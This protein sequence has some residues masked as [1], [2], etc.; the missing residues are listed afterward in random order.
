MK[1]NGGYATLQQLNHLVDFSTWGTKTPFASVRRI[2]QTNKE[3]F[4]I[5]PG[6]WALKEDEQM[7]LRKLNIVQSKTDSMDMFT[8]SYYQGILAEIGNMRNYDT[9]VPPQDKNKLFLEKKLS[10]ITSM[11]KIYE[12]TYPNIMKQAKTVDIIWFNERK[13]PCAFY[14]VEH[15]TNIKN[16]LNKFYELQDFRADFYIVAAQERKRQFDDIIQASIYNPIRNLVTFI[17]YT[18]LVKQYEG[19]SRKI[20]RVI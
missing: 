13:M 11:D 9:Y 8:H 15:S 6:L 18:S 14:E 16:S 5:Q 20:E 19:E 1:R 10:N 12:F 4:R 17:D 3:F 7:V 2:V